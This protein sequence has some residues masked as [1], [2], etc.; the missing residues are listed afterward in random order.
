MRAP[1]EADRMREI[2]SSPAFRA[3]DRDAEAAYYLIHFRQ[4]VPDPQLLRAIV[5][6]LRAHFDPARVRLARAIEDRLYEETSNAPGFDLIPGLA[7]IGTPTL[8][9]H[10]EDDLIPTD[11]ARHVADAMPDAT[12]S[13]LAGLGHFA[14]AQ[15]PDLV[16]DQVARFT[17][18]G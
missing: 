17:T 11:L 5:G 3:G 2:A 8:L 1:G 16:A 18:G 7:A 10:G 13:T 12:M 15:D 6:R 9:I 14:Y 4:T